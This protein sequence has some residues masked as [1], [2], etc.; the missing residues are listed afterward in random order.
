[1][2]TNSIARDPSQGNLTGSAWDD[3]IDFSL[4]DKRYSK[5]AEP[6]SKAASSKSASTNSDDW[7]K[8]IDLDSLNK[9]YLGVDSSKGPAIRA[10][11]SDNAD[12][13]TRITVTKGDQQAAQAKPS[14]DGFS[15]MNPDILKGGWQ[16]V[17]DVANSGASLIGYIDSKLSEAGVKRNE[18]FNQRVETEKAAIPEGNTA[19][20]VGRMGGQ[21]LATA[22]L[23]AA[24]P[25]MAAVKALPYVGKV[26]GSALRG[27]MG[28][29]MFGAATTAANDDGLASNIA[30][31]A[32]Y[33]A[34]AGP[35]VEG[36]AKVA[37]MALKKARDIG[38]AIWINNA[39]KNT[40]IDP[41][42][43]RYTL[44]RL[45]EAGHTPAEAEVLMKQLGPNATM[46]DLSPSLTTEV[47][48]LASFGGTATN[49]LK[50]RFGERAA[51]ANSAAHDLMETRLGAKP[52]FEAEKAA[53]KL[54]RQ[55][56]TSTDYNAA[57][58]S[59]MALD[60]KPV[61]SHID[62]EIAGG[63]VGSEAAVLEKARGYLHNSTGDIKADTRPLLKARQAIDHD[64]KK[65]VKEG[66]TQESSTY[67]AMN[68]VRK[69][70]DDVLKTNPDLAIADAKYAKLRTDFDGLDLGRKS[71]TNSG[72]YDNFAREFNGASPEKQE[73]MRKGIRIQI[74]DMMEKA[75][76]GE[77]SEAKR[78]FDKSTNNRK[79]IK[80]VFGQKGEDV[81]KEL[82]REVNK[83]AVEQTVSGNSF[84]AERRAVQN[85]PELGGGNNENHFMTDV[86]HGAMADAIGGSGVGTG[87][88]IA[89]GIASGL[90]KAISGERIKRTV[91]GGADLLSRQSQHG[92]SEAMDV[93]DRIERVT[94]RNDRKLPVDY[95][96]IRA[97]ATRAAVPAA[98]PSTKRLKSSID[99]VRGIR[100]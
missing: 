1:M 62:S 79:I 20:D 31:N 98:I 91:E 34:A 11:M 47:G 12:G 6:S 84:T 18:D 21:V 55:Q 90:R 80:L 58:Q 32:G 64:L 75:T 41:N 4:L 30:T 96:S 7:S 57:K 89:K 53:A 35:L 22:P 73:F 87:V 86:A 16:G 9:K 25:E 40:G 99:D 23:A 72:N 81:L 54:D 42:A 3:G 14:A 44:A 26:A 37:S 45:Q 48:G 97:L 82:E 83:R 56:K 38:Q 43:A 100:N 85:R 74:G 77:L 71:I 2:P 33:G 92:R 29:G 49:T 93:L 46:G 67:R 28:G 69:Q 68:D 65:M 59:N 10:S 66:T 13:I 60:V 19:Y 15:S 63:A 5:P 51:G 70:L 36:G 76:R 95:S 27:A 24:V 17:K 88:G 61:V 50:T 94:R 39:V 52:D 8:N 78:L